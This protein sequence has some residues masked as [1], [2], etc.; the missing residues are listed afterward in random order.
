MCP[1]IINTIGLVFNIVGAVILFR[2]GFPQPTH[3]EATLLAIQGPTA[4]KNAEQARKI[5][6]EYLCRSK[7]G[8][9]LVIIGFIFQ[10]GAVWIPT[11]HTT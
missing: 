8:L 1:Q 5:K 11:S 6:A 7:I 10:L 9:I 4:D 2:Y 3:E